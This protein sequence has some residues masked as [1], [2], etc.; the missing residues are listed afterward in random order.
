MGRDCAPEGIQVQGED[1]QQSMFGLFMSTNMRTQQPT[2]R[3]HKGECA[4]QSKE[5]S[6]KHTDT[7]IVL[8]VSQ[9][10]SPSALMSWDISRHLR[11][12]ETFRDISASKA[13][14]LK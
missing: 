5:E 1:N 12:L 2:L 6:Q 7:L 4:V 14:R 3:I 13:I 9:E 11:C 8:W 10:S